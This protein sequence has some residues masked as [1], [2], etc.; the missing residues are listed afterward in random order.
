ML[1]H[2]IRW[3]KTIVHQNPET[4]VQLFYEIHKGWPSSAF[5]PKTA[6]VCG[7]KYPSGICI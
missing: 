6:H 7:L 3:V 5:A 1:S 2:Q 4:P